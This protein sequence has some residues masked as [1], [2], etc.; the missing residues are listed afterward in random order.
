MMENEQPKRCGVLAHWL[1]RLV[2]KLAGW[3]IR[4]EPPLTKNCLIIAAPHTSNW[5]LILLLAAAF[6][7]HISISYM[8]KSTVFWWPL[9][10]IL[11]YLGGIPVN[12]ATSNN[13]VNQ[14]VEQIKVGDGTNLVVPASGTRSYA[15]YWKSGFYHIAKNAKIPLVCGYLDYAKKEAGLGPI[16]IPTELKA[17]MARLREFYGPISARY[18]EMKSRI[19]LKEEDLQN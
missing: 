4:G 6:S 9:G 18:P 5:D 10:P 16:F 15:D 13:L 2:L 1:G 19:R 7:F 8:I 11:Q 12:R 14:M 3:R 17:D